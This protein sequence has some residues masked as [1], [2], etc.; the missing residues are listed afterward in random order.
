VS[1]TGGVVSIAIPRS[2]AHQLRDSGW[3]PAAIGLPA[4]APPGLQVGAD[5]T[6]PAGTSPAVLAG[7]SRSIV[8]P[9]AATLPTH[10]A[11]VRQPD[12]RVS[13]GGRSGVVRRWTGCGGTDLSFS[14]VLLGGRGDLGV[15]LQIRQDDRADRTDE[16]LSTLRLGHS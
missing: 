1:D 3:N 12:R 2:W 5:L 13:F 6:G 14:E 8:A 7:A 9:F 15:Y 11:C 4:G 16:V 10:E